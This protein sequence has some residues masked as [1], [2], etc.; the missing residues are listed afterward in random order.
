MLVVVERQCAVVV[1]DRDEAAAETSLGDCHRGTG[2]GVDG[3]SV[4]LLTGEAFDAG[5]QVRRDALRDHCVLIEE[6]RIVGGEAVH[7]HRRGP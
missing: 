2:L 4:A 5:D 1:E 6:V 7:M 3:Q